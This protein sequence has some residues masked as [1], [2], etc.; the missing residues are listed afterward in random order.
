MLLPP[1]QKVFSPMTSFTKCPETF[2][3]LRRV[4]NGGV[5]QTFILL[6]QPGKWV[7]RPLRFL[8]RAG[9]RT[10]YSLEHGPESRICGGGASAGGAAGPAE[11]GVLLHDL[12]PGTRRK[13]PALDDRRALAP[14]VPGSTKTVKDVP[15]R[16]VRYVS[17]LD[18]KRKDGA[19]D[20]PG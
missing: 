8:Q 13:E 6:T 20:L 3:T 9:V 12:A 5:A 7:P 10:V 17:G 19:P 16:F 15:G 2:F 11:A 1:L 4:R 14:Y 18:K